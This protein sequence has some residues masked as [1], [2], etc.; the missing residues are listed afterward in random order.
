MYQ[1]LSSNSAGALCLEVNKF[2]EG[3]I[4][5]ILYGSPYSDSKYHYQ[6]VIQNIKR[7]QLND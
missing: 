5:W 7:N 1:I 6:A 4:N 2:L 3:N